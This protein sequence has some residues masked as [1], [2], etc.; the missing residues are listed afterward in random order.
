MDA[1]ATSGS[2]DKDRKATHGT[3]ALVRS[4]ARMKRH[5]EIESTAITVPI[6]Q[7]LGSFSSIA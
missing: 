5:S 7:V 4:N 1:L 3:F 2:S 6:K